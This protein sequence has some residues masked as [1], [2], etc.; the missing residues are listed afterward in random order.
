[1][2]APLV[3]AQRMLLTDSP[4]GWPVLPQ[5][6]L[7]GLRAG[8]GTLWH[9]RDCAP[10]WHGPRLDHDCVADCPVRLMH[11][12]LAQRWFLVRN[13][14][15]PGFYPDCTV[16]GRVHQYISAGCIEKPF[17]GETEVIGLITDHRAGG[18]GGVTRGFRL[19]A[20]VPIKRIEAFMLREKIRAKGYPA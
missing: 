20:L 2:S 9:H 18:P 5:P 7:D 8:G 1:M 19:G 11:E 14:S 15:I 4:P 17:N 12:V 16:C 10:H 13:E 3:T 6:L